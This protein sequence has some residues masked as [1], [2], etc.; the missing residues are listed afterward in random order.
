MG[1]QTETSSSEFVAPMEF[2]SEWR[3]IELLQS[4][5]HTMLYVATRYGRRFL[6]KSL[7]PEAARLTDYQT[8]LGTQNRSGCPVDIYRQ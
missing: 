5:S 3:N 8:G 6:L 7:T 1:L 4:R 2:S